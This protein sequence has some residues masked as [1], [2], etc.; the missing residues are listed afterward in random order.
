MRSGAPDD[1]VRLLFE[2]RAAGDARRVL[3]LLDPDV[4]VQTFP[5]GEIVDGVAAVRRTFGRGPATGPRIEVEA[6]R[7]EPEGGD[8]VRV[9]GRVRVI[10]HGTLSDSPGAW[11][12]LVRGGRV[13]AIAPLEA[14]SAAL[15]R[16]A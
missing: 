16:V 2:S 6:H 10:E 13:V 8:V 4:Q 9:Y 15:L 11:R 7:I 3:A 1:V 12:F 14:P 5:D